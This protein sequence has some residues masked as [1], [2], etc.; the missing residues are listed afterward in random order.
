MVG[1][2]ATAL[3]RYP[4]FPQKREEKLHWKARLFVLLRDS[5]PT[6]GWGRLFVRYLYIKGNILRRENGECSACRPLDDVCRYSQQ[7][8]VSSIKAG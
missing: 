8:R 1:K 4:R 7:V 6:S 5:V 2:I 3:L